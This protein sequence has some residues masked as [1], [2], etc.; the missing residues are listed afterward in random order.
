M[1]RHDFAQ[2]GYLLVTA[3]IIMI[4]PSSGM[5]FAIMEMLMT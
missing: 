1:F 5:G 3:M 2:G 4:A